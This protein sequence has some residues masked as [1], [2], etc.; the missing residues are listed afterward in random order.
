M[1]FALDHLKTDDYLEKIQTFL[2]ICSH[3]A[4]L[5]ETFTE[6]KRLIA[7]LNSAL[8]DSSCTNKS[9]VLQTLAIADEQGAVNKARELL[10]AYEE[11]L[12]DPS[13]V[14]VS[15][16]NDEDFCESIRVLIKSAKI[17]ALPKLIE[18][19]TSREEMSPG[20]TRQLIRSV[21]SGHH[22]IY[23]P[24]FWS[25]DQI[26]RVVQNLVT[27]ATTN[28]LPFSARFQAFD[29]TQAL[30]QFQKEQTLEEPFGLQ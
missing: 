29:I 19:L 18:L 13:S 16:M 28:P 7:Q 24:K 17:Q 3:S 22:R 30:L 27:L 23:G 26:E 14:A 11:C 25:D 2:H 15:E 20:S 5:L 4:G 9:K 6:R 12:K 21:T 10:E 8:D 1:D